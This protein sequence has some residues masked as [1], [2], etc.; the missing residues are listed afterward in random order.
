MKEERYYPVYLFA[1]SAVIFLT[2]LGSRDF[3]SP[4][5]PRY[6]EIVRVMFVKNQWIVPT[7]NGELYTD[8]PILYFW[9]AL[10]FSKI[11]GAVNEW[12]VRLPAALGAIGMVLIT[13]KLGKDFYS[14]RVGLIAGAVLAT[15][16]RVIWEGR[17]AHLDALF[18]FFFALAMYFAAHATLHRERRN[19]FLWAY[20]LMALATLTKGLIGVVLP[21]LILVVFV[22]V[23]REWRLIRAAR[24][25][26]GIVLFLLIAAPWFVA[27]HPG[28][29]RQV[30]RRVRLYSPYPALYE[31]PGPSRTVLLLPENHTARFSSVDHILRPRSLRLQVRFQRITPAAHVIFLAVVFGRVSLFQRFGHQA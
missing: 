29:R 9:L 22:L 24:L 7:V 25:P 16:A 27:C 15:S 10:M 1:L 14:P 19:Q 20:A 12:T 21:A 4:V 2:G 8:K 17:W 26:S 23:T 18:A 30:V 31:R 13:Y 6:A 11:F 5:E 28:H 3:W